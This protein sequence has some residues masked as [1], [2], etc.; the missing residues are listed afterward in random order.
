MCFHI[1]NFGQEGHKNVLKNCLASG[2]DA[3]NIQN[4]SKLPMQSIILTSRQ[5]LQRMF[6]VSLLRS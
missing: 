4:I 1:M 5:V 6:S 2:M 3:L